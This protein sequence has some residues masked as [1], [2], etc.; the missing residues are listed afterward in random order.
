MTVTKLEC[1]MSIEE[2]EAFIL[3]IDSKD[4]YIYAWNKG[5]TRSVDYGDDGQDFTGSDICNVTL[6]RNNK[7][8][9]IGIPSHRAIGFFG[10]NRS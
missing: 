1:M 5:D 10:I 4:L 8:F 7:F 3:T 6:A 2:N 9:A